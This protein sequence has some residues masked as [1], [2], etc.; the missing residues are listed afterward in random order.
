M[1]VPTKTGALKQIIMYCFLWKD[2]GKTDTNS[3]ENCCHCQAA[4]PNCTN[5]FLRRMTNTSKELDPE[6]L[7]TIIQQYALDLRRGGFHQN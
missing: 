4:H 7:E 6:L 3:F 1:Q 2:N 5:E